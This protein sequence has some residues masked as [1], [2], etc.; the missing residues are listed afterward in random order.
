METKGS[1]QY[2]ELVALTPSDSVFSEKAQWTFRSMLEAFQQVVLERHESIED[3]LV[4]RFK[5]VYGDRLRLHTLFDIPHDSDESCSAEVLCLDGAP[6]LLFKRVGD[7]SDYSDGLSIIDPALSK[8]FLEIFTERFNNLALEK[9]AAL[10][11]SLP[12]MADLIASTHYLGAVNDEVFIVISPKWAMGLSHVIDDHSTWL[13]DE[14]GELSRVDKFKQWVNKSL[15]WSGDPECNDAILIMANGKE[16]TANCK[17]LLFTLYK[18]PSS[19]AVLQEAAQRLQKCMELESQT[20][21]RQR[22]G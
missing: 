7:R 10:Q 1:K 19:L 4:D 9:M 3:E 20:D 12:S 6:V 21:Q 13:I 14:Q 18:E 2:K 8:G 22:G 5:A 17:N 11:E 15:S 16:I